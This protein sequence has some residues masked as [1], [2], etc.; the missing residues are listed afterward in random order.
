MVSIGSGGVSLMGRPTR[1][2][3]KPPAPAEDRCQRE[4][5]IHMKGSP[6]YVDW[7]ESIHRKT[8]IPKVQIFRIA[9]AEWAERNGHGAPP[10]I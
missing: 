3:G 4:T 10:E 1:S 8:H 9:I 2:A 5:V 7:L 6:E